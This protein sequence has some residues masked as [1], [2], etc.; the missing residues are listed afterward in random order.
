M[1]STRRMRFMI[2]GITV[3]AAAATAFVIGAPV[4]TAAPDPSPTV[5]YAI[6]DSVMLGAKSHLKRRGFAVNATVSRQAYS[7]PAM[8][9][10]RGASLPRTLVVHLGTN[11]TFPLET[12][13][14]IAQN[15]GPS[16]R[17]F[18]VTVSVPR[19]WERSNN[20]TIRRCASSFP[21]GRVSVVDWKRLA[22]RHPEWFA[23]DRVHLTSAGARGYARLIDQA[24]SGG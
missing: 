5:G 17:V 8:V 10:K 20:A 24:V 3:V 7:A 18:L 11:G 16:R 19:S 6:G 4:A 23:S 12:C 1:P 2:R 15:A 13:R 22:S 14:R 9:R 21:D